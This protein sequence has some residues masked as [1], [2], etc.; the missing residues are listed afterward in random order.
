MRKKIFQQRHPGR[1][2]HYKRLINCY[3]W[4]LLRRKKI[5]SQPLC[6]DCLAVGRV[7]VAEEVHHNIPVERGRTLEEMRELAYDFGNL[8]SLC[9]A[10]HQARHN[11][12]GVVKQQETAFTKYFFSSKK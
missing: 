1:Y 4:Q 5:A 6:E 7:T 11:P 10:C 2:E 9:R 12:Q 8:V 3:T